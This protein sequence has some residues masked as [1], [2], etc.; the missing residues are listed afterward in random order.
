MSDDEIKLLEKKLRDMK[1]KAIAE[2][3]KVASTFAD[4]FNEALRPKK[5]R[6][7]YRSCGACGQRIDNI[8]GGVN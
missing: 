8:E 4:R 7:K 6:R 3:P 1:K 5:I 2:N